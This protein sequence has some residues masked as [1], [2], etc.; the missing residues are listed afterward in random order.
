ME[1]NDLI[2]KVLDLKSS[3]DFSIIQGWPGE[4]WINYVIS[5]QYKNDDILIFKEDLE[6]ESQLLLIDMHIDNIFMRS[7]MDTIL[8]NDNYKKIFE[9]FFLKIGDD[10]EK[11]YHYIFKNYEDDKRNKIFEDTTE[12]SICKEEIQKLYDRYLQN[13]IKLSCNRVFLHCLKS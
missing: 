8:E 10:I 13:K 11:L 3:H 6:K 1:Y 9:R 2:S 7:W 4:F 12:V 5:H